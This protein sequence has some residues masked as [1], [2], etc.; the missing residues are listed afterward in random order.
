MEKRKG[1]KANIFSN[2]KIVKRTMRE[3]FLKEKLPLFT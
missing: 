1:D 2:I 3:L